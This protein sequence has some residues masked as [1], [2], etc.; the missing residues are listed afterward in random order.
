MCNVAGYNDA[1]KIDK[2]DTHSEM[3]VTRLKNS[4]DDIFSDSFLTHS[5]TSII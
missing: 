2:R 5:A 1:N 3:Q 4:I